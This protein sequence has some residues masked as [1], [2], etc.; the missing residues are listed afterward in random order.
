MTE[1]V[2]ITKPRTRIFKWIG[3]GVYKQYSTP[4]SHTISWSQTNLTGA[5]YNTVRLGGGNYER[6]RCQQFITPNFTVKIVKVVLHVVKNANFTDTV[7]VRICP[8]NGSNMPDVNNVIATIGTFTGSDV[9]TS[10][11]Q[12]TFTGSVP[13][14][15]ANTKYWVVVER[16]TTNTSQY[17]S[18]YLSSTDYNT[19]LYSA[20]SYGSN[21]TQRTYDYKMRI[22]CYENPNTLNIDFI[23][24]GPVTKRL[25]VSA[26]VSNTTI[27]NYT[28][29]SQTFTSIT[30]E[31]NIPQSNIYTLTVN[32][33]ENTAQSS[34]Y[35]N[36]TIQ[37]WLYYSSTSCTLEHL[38]VSEAYVQ[39]ILFGSTG[40]VLRIDDDPSADLVGQANE[41]IV[42][43]DVIVPFR[44]LEWV[45][46]NGEVMILGVE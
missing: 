5:S 4:I 20:D 26:S 45:S 34:G 9:G 21:W 1:L 12:L 7:Y 43:I 28:L 22:F 44:K 14:L 38:N 39:E 30:R 27:N 24:D 25:N 31:T 6:Y 41:K 16:P 18:L 35:V 15:Q 46:G 29:N 40:G 32:Y 17:P 11:T 13:T 3:G 2:I 33:T 36:L 19:S 42:F 8:D 10:E 23:Y 37:R